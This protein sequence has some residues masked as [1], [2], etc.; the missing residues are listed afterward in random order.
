ME[1]SRVFALVES[2]NVYLML[3]SFRKVKLLLASGP[4]FNKLDI[5][6]SKCGFGL[7][8]LNFGLVDSCM[9]SKLLG[10]VHC[11]STYYSAK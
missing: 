5:C 1:E 7:V 8:L 2:G 6:S 11:A 4:N 3:G 9:N 10:C